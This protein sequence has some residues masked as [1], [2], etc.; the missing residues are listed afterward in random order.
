[1][2]AA[3]LAHEIFGAALGNGAKVVYRLLLAQANAVVGDGERLGGFVKG[4]ADF[5]LGV[6]FE[7]FGR[8]DRFKAQLVAGV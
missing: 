6:A 8:V 2:V 1:M 5:E 3:E 4:D 7:Q